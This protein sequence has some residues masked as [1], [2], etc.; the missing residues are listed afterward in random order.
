[1][2]AV[3]T[4]TSQIHIVSFDA[5]RK[6]QQIRQSWDQGSL[7][8]LIDVIGKTGRNWPIHAGKDQIRLITASVKLTG[9]PATE[10]PIARSRGN[11]QNVTRDPHA[12]LAL[13]TPREKVSPDYRPA[14]VAPRASAKPP[15]RDYHDLF[16]GNDSDQSPE[17]PAKAKGGKERAPSPS[18]PAAIPTKVGA[19]K[20]FAPSRLFDTGE[21]DPA[22]PPA[23]HP[24][25]P[26]PAKYQHFEF[27]DGSDPQD[28]PKQV[29]LRPVNNKHGS[30][31]DFDDF[32][33]PAKVNPTKALR[34]NDVRHWGTEDDEPVDSP[35]KQK[36]VP[37]ARKD[38]Q[39]NF[40][41][42][43]DG[44][45]EGGPRLVGRQR[46]ADQ[47]KG[48]GLYKNNV[49]DEDNTGAVSGGEFNRLDTISNI[50]D[51]SKDFDPHFALT[52]DSPGIKPAAGRLGDDRAKAVKMMDASWTTYDQSPTQKENVPASTQRPSAATAKGPLSESTN[53]SSKRNDNSKGIYTAGDG[54]GG[55][56]GAGRQWS[57]GDESGGEDAPVISKPGKFKTGK[58]QG[59]GSQPT[60]GGFW[61][62]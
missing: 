54:M 43:D 18:K 22:Q 59:S 31:W 1:M 33:T 24:Y 26:N 21:D 60:G 34:N 46:G 13:F 11:S 62:F 30:Q 28:T 23:D 6:I 20:N 52:D 9:T 58:T 51:R 45:P 42:R 29:P 37:K 40:E 47:N 27:G 2:P 55:K 4:L 12:S 44:T 56:K 39:T 8:K 48:L 15:P 10:D 50:K 61:D 3:C 16:V 32:V 14:V 53:T 19:G 57:I 49:Y 17:T 41:F 7:L 25:R 35:I 38:A 36:L 5:E